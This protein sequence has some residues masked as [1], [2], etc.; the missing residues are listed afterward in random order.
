LPDIDASTSTESQA[1]AVVAL[2]LKRIDK[3]AVYGSV[4]LW[5]PA[6]RLRIF[7]VLWGHRANGEEW[8]RLPSRSWT[9]EDG[10]THYTKLLSWGDDVTERRFRKAALA[11]IR[12]LL[13]AN[14]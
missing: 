7:E 12:R 5:L 4:T 10:A 3:G 2:D 1:P 13:E 8:V 11:A 9:A 6:I 14:P